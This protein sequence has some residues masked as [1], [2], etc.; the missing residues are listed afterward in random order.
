MKSAAIPSDQM[1]IAARVP[2]G[3]WSPGLGVLPPSF[4]IPPPIRPH[5][6]AAARAPDAGLDLS[7][8]AAVCSSVSSVHPGVQPDSGLAPRAVPL[9]VAWTRLMLMY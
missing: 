7:H 4:G 9:S 5:A 6:A 3:G 1:R 2:Q 8:F